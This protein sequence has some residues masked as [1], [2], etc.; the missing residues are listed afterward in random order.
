[1]LAGS[2]TWQVCLATFRTPHLLRKP[3]NIASAALCAL[4]A[5]YKVSPVES[6]RRKQNEKA[7]R[8]VCSSFWLPCSWLRQLL[9][10]IEP[11]TSLKQTSLRSLLRKF[12]EHKLA[13]TH[14]ATASDP[15]KKSKQKPQGCCLEAFVL[16]S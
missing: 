9:M 16:A 4:S 3:T 14:L 13:V 6:K 1:M 8:L 5:K 15:I 11:V 12:A 2:Q 10:D 7:D